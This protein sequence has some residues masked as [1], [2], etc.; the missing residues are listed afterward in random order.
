MTARKAGTTVGS[1]ERHS[2]HG[3]ACVVLLAEEEAAQYEVVEHE[4]TSSAADDARVTRIAPERVAKTLLLRDHGR[5]RAAVIP[6]SEHL[7]LHKA[8]A[9]IRG[10]AALKLASEQEMREAFAMLEPGALPPFGLGVPEVVDRR[11]LGEATVLCGGGDHRHGLLI[12]PSEI[13]R[14]GHAL[15]SDICRA[16]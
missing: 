3:F 10:T 8:R 16:R 5:L 13:V 6:A 12:P 9:A 7:D 4:G 11:L 15:V 2:W 1:A 14:L